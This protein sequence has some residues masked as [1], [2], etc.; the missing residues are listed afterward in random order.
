MS[1]TLYGSF[2]GINNYGVNKKHKRPGYKL[3]ERGN[4]VNIFP[5]TRELSPGERCGYKNNKRE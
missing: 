5:T 4:G 1:V 2:A 3:Y